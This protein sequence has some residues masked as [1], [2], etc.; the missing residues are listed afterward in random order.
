VS[1]WA[2]NQPPARAERCDP[3][4]PT[5]SRCRR[6]FDPT[7]RLFHT[8]DSKGL[9]SLGGSPPRLS[10]LG[11]VHREGI[12]DGEGPSLQGRLPGKRLGDARLDAPIGPMVRCRAQAEGDRSRYSIGELIRGSR[13][14]PF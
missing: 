14:T 1:E 9:I 13:P 3:L 2:V 10:D 5:F 12:A 6:R 4:A 11:S 8:R 7:S